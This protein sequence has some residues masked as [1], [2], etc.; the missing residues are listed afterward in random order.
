MFGRVSS[1][2]LAAIVAALIYSNI[3]LWYLLTNDSAHVRDSGAGAVVGALICGI[4][5]FGIAMII[6]RNVSRSQT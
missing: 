4:V 2:L 1:A 3:D 6:A 5:A